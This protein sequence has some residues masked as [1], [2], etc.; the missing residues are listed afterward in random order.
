MTSGPISLPAHSTTGT[1]RSCTSDSVMIVLYGL[2][3]DVA[4]H[5]SLTAVTSTCR[6][7]A[8]KLC[9]L[10][11]LE[12]GECGP[13]I[14]QEKRSR[15][16]GTIYSRCDE[17]CSA[18]R[19][20]TGLCSPCVR[21]DVPMGCLPTPGSESRSPMHQG[22]RGQRLRSSL[23]DGRQHRLLLATSNLHMRPD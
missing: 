3:I 19:S 2:R 10:Q 4:G 14:G 6:R 5:C 12:H 1:E 17:R 11:S 8:A 18:T 16:P 21:D 13:F 9:S 23:Q 15:A 7:P 22:N 20:Q